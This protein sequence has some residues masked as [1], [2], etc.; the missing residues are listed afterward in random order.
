[1]EMIDRND[2]YKMARENKVKYNHL[3]K[4]KPDKENNF[5]SDFIS[6]HREDEYDDNREGSRR[7]RL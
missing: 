3:Y 2:L 1:M 7:Q 6:Y 4:I 5:N